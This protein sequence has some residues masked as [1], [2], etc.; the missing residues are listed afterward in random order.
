M[1][2]HTYSDGKREWI[3]EDLWE[4][5]KD[6]EVFEADTKSFIDQ[7]EESVWGE[8]NGLDLIA[9]L[10]KLTHANF[11]YPI[12]LDPEGYIM[13]G[14]HRLSKA[15]LERR[16]TIPVVMFDKDNLPDPSYIREK[17]NFL[18]LISDT[19]FVYHK[20]ENNVMNCQKYMIEAYNE[21]DAFKAVNKMFPDRYIQ[22]LRD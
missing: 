10:Y 3:V 14:M 2:L 21:E 11:D 19:S 4:A 6:L 8:M 15:F 13:D 20:W 22:I 17:D 9:H 1:I 7:L 16:E 5:A 18:F 12:I